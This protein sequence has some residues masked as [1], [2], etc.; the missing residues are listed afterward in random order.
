MS[1]VKA[2][3]GIAAVTLFAV[4]AC[5]AVMGAGGAGLVDQATGCA[6]SGP[7]V[8]QAGATSPPPAA[9]GAGPASGKLPTKIGIY[10]GVQLVNAGHVIKAGQSLGLDAWT[11]T[12]GVMTVMGESGLRVLDRG[13][14]AGPDSRGLWQQRAGGAWG[15]GCQLVCVSGGAD[16]EGVH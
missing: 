7:A 15:R 2:A 1:G 16:D 9:P 11:I 8:V 5:T 13:D 3:G 4:G 6:P 14:A 12:T 10:S